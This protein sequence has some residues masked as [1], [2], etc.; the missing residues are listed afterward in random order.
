LAVFGLFS[1]SIGVNAYAIALH[2]EGYSQGGFAVAVADLVLASVPVGWLIYLISLHTY[3]IVAKRSTIELILES[4]K[5]ARP[6][7][8]AIKPH[9][10]VNR[11][12]KL[13]LPTPHVAFKDAETPLGNRTDP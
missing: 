2:P 10:D 5:R 7:S 4:R 8:I 6:H 13:E 12:V 1:L 3:L 11:I 9:Q